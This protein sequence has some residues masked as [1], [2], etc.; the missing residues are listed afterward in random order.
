VPLLFLNEKSFGTSCEPARAERAMARMAMAVVAVVKAD[1]DG[2]A[3]VGREPFL[4]TQIAEGHPVT[5]W[6]NTQD[7]RD[8]R[9]RLMLMQSRWPHSTVFP[10]GES[11]A[12]SEYR[13]QGAVV[14]GLGAAH[15][16]DGVGV[17]LPVDPRWDDAWLTLDRER[18]AESSDGT[19]LTDTDQV[20]LR[21]L[22]HE[23]HAKTHERWIAAGADA[24]R[25]GAVLSADTG[26][27]L[28]AARAEIFPHLTFLPAVRR[29][30]SELAKPSV[31][32]VREKLLLLEIAV[33]DWDPERHPKAPAW[34]FDVR[35]EFEQRRRLCH[36]LD[37][38]RSQL[39]ELHCDFL[40]RP[41]RIHFRI[42][43]ADHTVRIAHIGRKLGV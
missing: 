3:I 1:R 30:L 23:D 29:Q 8:L 7:N 27:E 5:K 31:P 16:M 6:L 43:H 14:E 4:Q 28:W 25:R 22:S 24:R 32:S 41:G 12:E 2:T 38:G 9:Q 42:E 17:S 37:E 13:H 19:T 10:D 34:G 18:L 11:F 36:F 20:P 15:L 39:F 26:A 33:R 40:P 35:S 21:H